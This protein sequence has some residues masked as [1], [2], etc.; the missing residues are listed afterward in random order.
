M[1]NGVPNSDAPQDWTFSDTISQQTAVHREAHR[2]LNAMA[3]GGVDTATGLPFRGQ[4]AWSSGGQMNGT[5]SP[6][7]VNPEPPL[8][9]GVTSVPTLAPEDRPRNFEDLVRYPTG[10]RREK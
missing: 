10:G 1:K 3:E 7:V 4:D 9:F 2:R 6:D 5:M 8:G